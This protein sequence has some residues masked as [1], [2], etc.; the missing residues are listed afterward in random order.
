MNTITQY[1]GPDGS[2]TIEI[3]CCQ[4][5]Q[6]SNSPSYEYNYGAP[7]YP[8]Y[9]NP[10]QSNSPSYGYNYGAPSYPVYQNSQP[11]NNPS[12]GNAYLP[13]YFYPE[14]ERIY[15][16]PNETGVIYKWIDDLGGGILDG[17]LK[18]G[19]LRPDKKIAHIG[20]VTRRKDGVRVVEYRGNRFPSRPQ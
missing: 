4:N 5:P 10:Q 14:G 7:S 3:N 2:I 9:Q 13:L 15:I 11:L 16:L 20:T 19:A 6:Q 1:H 12:Y 18:R 8:V 17:P